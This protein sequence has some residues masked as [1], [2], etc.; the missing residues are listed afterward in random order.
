MALLNFKKPVM[1]ELKHHAVPGCEPCTLVRANEAANAWTPDSKA[2]LRLFPQ[3]A[4]WQDIILIT[5]RFEA[6]VQQAIA[7]T[8]SSVFVY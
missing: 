4:H 8:V 7:S 1:T 5:D 6:D 3:P 2:T